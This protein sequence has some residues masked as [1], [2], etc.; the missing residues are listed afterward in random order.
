MHADKTSI[1]FNYMESFKCLLYS[2]KIIQ[3]SVKA[4]NA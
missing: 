4:T 2:I 1:I 3:D